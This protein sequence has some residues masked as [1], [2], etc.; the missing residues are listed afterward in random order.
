MVLVIA[1]LWGVGTYID[2]RDG[3]TWTKRSRYEDGPLIKRVD[4]HTDP[5]GFKL[6]AVLRG[7]MPVVLIGTLGGVLGL[8]AVGHRMNA[9]A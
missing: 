2:L 8:A 6:V 7:V 1:T 9:R 5:Q 3:S 4:L